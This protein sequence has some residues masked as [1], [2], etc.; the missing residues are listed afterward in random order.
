MSSAVTISRIRFGEPNSGVYVLIIRLA[1]AQQITVGAM[2][3]KSFPAGWYLYTGSARQGMRQ[4]IQRHFRRDKPHRWHIDY[5]TTA[6]A[7]RPIGAVIV[8]DDRLPECALN[9]LVGDHVGNHAHVRGFGASDCRSGCPAHLWYSVSP[10]P[11]LEVAG[12]VGGVAITA[13]CT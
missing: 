6:E 13:A 2:G 9:K 10:V 4:R 11:M 7:A 8:A 3:R 1:H 12:V 5:M